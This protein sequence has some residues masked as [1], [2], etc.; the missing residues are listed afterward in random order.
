MNTSI[1]RFFPARPVA[2]RSV[3]RARRAGPADPCVSGLSTLTATVSP[4]CAARLCVFAHTS[5]A[6]VTSHVLP[7]RVCRSPHTAQVTV[8]RVVSVMATAC[9]CGERTG[10]YTVCP[11]APDPSAPIVSSV[12]G[13]LRPIAC[14]ATAGS[15]LDAVAASWAIGSEG[16]G[17]AH[18]GLLP[19]EPA[20]S[21]TATLARR[22]PG[23]ASPRPASDADAGLCR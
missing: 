10:C 4:W 13:Q 7:R 6:T 15:D 1:G 20:G 17:G 12:V 8:A 9:H 11:P 18:A 16:D 22:A 2:Y 23:G 5:V 3:G 19:W 14:D 21:R